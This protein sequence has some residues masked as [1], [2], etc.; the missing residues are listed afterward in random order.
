MLKLNKKNKKAIE[1]EVLAW[2]IMGLLVLV[3]AVVA[4]V[5]M[6]S[7]GLSAINYI[8]GLFRFR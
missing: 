8:K 3:I 2:W 7:K 4:A 1:L 6:K 5:Y